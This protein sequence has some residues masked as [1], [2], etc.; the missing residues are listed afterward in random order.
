MQEVTVKWKNKNPF[1]DF[2]FMYLK[3]EAKLSETTPFDEIEHFAIE[4]TPEGYGLQKIIIN[5][6]ETNYI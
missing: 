4:A 6:E 2:E 5:G 1:V 3:S